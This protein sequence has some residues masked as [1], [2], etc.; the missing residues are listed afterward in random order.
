MISANGGL[1]AYRYTPQVTQRWPRG[2]E[3]ASSRRRR[4]QS[5]GPVPLQIS[6]KFA[7]KHEGIFIPYPCT[8]KTKRNA[9]SPGKLP[10]DFNFW[11]TWNEEFLWEIKYA[12]RRE[13]G[14]VKNE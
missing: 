7:H 4:S 9:P 13:E 6:R 2:S 10:K 1:P 11:G 12:F 5:P 14:G 3:P 8:Q